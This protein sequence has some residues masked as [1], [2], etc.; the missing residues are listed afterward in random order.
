[1]T[2]EVDETVTLDAGGE[3]RVPTVE[4]LT[5]RG[6]VTGKSGSGKS[7]T[8]SVV[9]EELLADG[10]PLLIVD[11]DGEYYGLKERYE[12]L[13]AG[14]DEECD[15]QVGSEHAGKL[16][17]LAL[18]G[19]VPVILDVSAYLDDE[20]HELVRAVV[21]ALF[22]REREA[23][24]P[25][26]L[27]V[28]EVHEFIPESGGLDGAGKM[29]VRVAKRGRKRGLGFC[30]ISQ[31]PA[32]V[33][34]DV[35]TQCDWL[36]W[37]RLT[38]DNDTSVV[39]RVLDSE[40]A[41]T[42]QNL[43]DGE[44]VLVTDWDGMRRRVQVRRKETFDAGATPGLGGVERP[45]LKSIGDG[46]LDDLQAISERQREREDRLA[47]L[48][49]ELEQRD[50]RIAELEAKLDRARD[51][52]DMAEQF[53]R[54]L[55]GGGGENARTAA[56]QN[57]ERRADEDREHHRG[58]DAHEGDTDSTEESLA[59]PGETDEPG[60][61]TEHGGNDTYA[62]LLD[63]EVVRHQIQQAEAHSHA[64]P[65]YAKGVIATLLDENGP[66]AHGTILTRLGTATTAD[67]STAAT[68]L[69]SMQVIDKAHTDEGLMVDLNRDG[70][71]EVREAT[72]GR[73]R[74]REV[75][76]EL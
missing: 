31:R 55:A 76:E 33:K 29:L 73:E 60:P 28:E 38:W 71:R 50:E 35:I 44:A 69:E 70:I 5:G 27:L 16:A 63:I 57:G 14:A 2:S 54:A 74:T 19:S 34:K 26:L 1:M 43:D 66:V 68:T 48:E 24:R 36:C 40:T 45:E 8:A 75:A 61:S 20:G 13:H 32:N 10:H 6:F 46:L 64:S 52:S 41:D 30:G 9:A 53:T 7:N 23:R 37:H 15:V 65:E 17:E 51:L 21:E 11:T 25:F 67:I 4:L 62:D 39:R 58:R 22:T 42:V 47:R 18:D 12:V 59:R 56:S 72:V 3:I 49:R